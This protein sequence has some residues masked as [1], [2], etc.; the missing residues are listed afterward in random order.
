MAR[1]GHRE[2]AGR[3][4]GFGAYLEP[5]KPIRIPLSLI[6]NIMELLKTHCIKNPYAMTMGSLSNDDTPLPCPL[7]SN[8]VAAGFPSPC[9]DHI[10]DMLDLN[11]LLITNRPAT[12]YVRVSGSSMV[13]AG[14]NPGDLLL[15]DR[16]LEAK[17][18]SIII[19]AV[20]GELTVKRLYITKTT[21]SLLPENSDFPPIPITD[22]MDF[23]IWGVVKH[24]IHTVG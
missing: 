18:N 3:K 14:I 5:T 6:P 4:K 20:N 23:H 12:F 21:M 7:Y 16:S 13:G 9:D 2:G 1:G 17:N 11:Q 8:K 22:E 19:A 15:V 24:V 10:E